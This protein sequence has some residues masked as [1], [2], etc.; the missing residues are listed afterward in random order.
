[1]TKITNFRVFNA[2][3]DE[4]AADAFGNNVAF[5]CKC[6]HPV[7]AIVRERHRGSHE[8]NPAKCRNCPKEYVWVSVDEKAE[9]I[10]IHTIDKK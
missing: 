6:G 4:I 1:M 3:G 8:G 5:K 7:L 2:D 9:K 10:C